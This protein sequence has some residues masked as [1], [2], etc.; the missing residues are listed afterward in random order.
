MSVTLMTSLGELKLELYCEQAP[1]TSRN[2]LALAA[3]GAYDGCQFH[4]NIASF[5]IQGGDPTGSGS[6]G[7]AADGGRLDDEIVEA[8]QHDRR[9]RVAM[10][11]AALRQATAAA[12]PQRLTAA[13]P[14]CSLFSSSQANRGPNTAGSQSEDQRATAGG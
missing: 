13:A 11:S 1:R 7:A 9:G 3:S 8:L 12:A 14:L 5:I 2:F 4:R 10:V 6:G